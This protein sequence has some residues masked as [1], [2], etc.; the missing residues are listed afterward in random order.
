MPFSEIV[1]H[2]RQLEKLRRALQGSRLHHAYLF[3]G[4]PGVGKR[5]VAL[6]LAKAIFC[7][8]QEA[9]FCGAC[10]NCVRIREGHHP[11]VRVVEPQAGKREITIQQVRDLEKELAFRPFAGIRKVAI[12]DPADLMNYHAQNSLLK[13]LEEPPGNSL[14]VLIATRLKGL[15]PTLL[16]RCL[17]LSFGFVP[18]QD[19]AE[20]LA[21]RKDITQ[22]RARLLAALTMGSPGEALRLHGQELVEE[23][24]EWNRRLD[25]LGQGD[26]QRLLAFADEIASDKEK[27]ARFIHW[28]ESWYQDTLSYQVTAEMKNVRNV[29][30]CQQIQEQASRGK[31]DDTLSVLFHLSKTA[32]SLQK[33]YNRRMIFEDL[34][35]KVTRN[36]PGA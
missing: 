23:R 31:I 30:L 16:S 10:V 2:R 4:P 12:I 24:K 8:H 18:V 5:T 17:R 11:D 1:G 27:S 36:K 14:L 15:L 34:L 35:I 32:G 33:N 21:Q 6:A 25:A 26:Y 28:A 22:D 29:D 3:L 20:F 7:A 13:T 9:D 19:V